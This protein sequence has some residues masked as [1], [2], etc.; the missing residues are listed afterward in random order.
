MRWLCPPTDGFAVG[1]HLIVPPGL[2]AHEPHAIEL[3]EVGLP[4]RGQDRAALAPDGEVAHGRGQE[5]LVGAA[6]H[7]VIDDRPQRGGDLR[8]RPGDGLAR[9]HRGAREAQPR[10]QGD[11]LGEAPRRL[12]PIRGLVV[13]RLLGRDHHVQPGAPVVGEDQVRAA[14]LE[15]RQAPGVLS[16]GVVPG[17]VLEEREE[18]VLAHRP[19]PPRHL[20][21]GQQAE[22][23]L[24]RGGEPRVAVLAEGAPAVGWGDGRGLEVADRGGQDDGPGVRVAD[25]VIEQ[26]RQIVVAAQI[27]ETHGVEQC[28]VLLVPVRAADGHAGQDQPDLRIAAGRLQ[29]VGEHRGDAPA[30][31]AE[32]GRGEGEVRGDIDE[33]TAS[34]HVVL[35]GGLSSARP[36]G[37]QPALAAPLPEKLGPAAVAGKLEDRIGH[38]PGR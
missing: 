21:R 14:A 15:Q 35:H 1:Q 23:V 37:A 34:D 28:E 6:P 30:H 3:I 24:P 8:G 38:R 7:A 11:H 29:G 36:P 26:P 5:G 10:A 19:H 27:G 20:G 32:R 4:P 2:D 16:S 25:Q 18:H 22:L 33:R 12:L 13:T 9:H 31:G 17:G